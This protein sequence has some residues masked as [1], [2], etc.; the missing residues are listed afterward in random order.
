MKRHLGALLGLVLAWT[1]GPRVMAQPAEL[2]DN[3]KTAASLGPADI[4]AVNAFV[5]AQVQRIVKGDTAAQSDARDSLINQSTNR[6]KPPEAAYLDAYAAAL[7]Q[8]I[9]SQIPADAPIRVRL[10][11]AIATARVA[12]IASN[13][14]LVDAVLRW[15][16][17]QE[18]PVVLW[19]VKGARFVLTPVLDNTPLAQRVKLPQ[20]IVQAVQKNPTGPV[21]QEAYTALSLGVF[22]P[23]A[24]AIKPAWLNDTLPALFDLLGDRV[25]RYVAGVPDEPQAE[26]LATALLV[27]PQVW[28]K[29]SADQRVK[30]VQLMYDL[31]M[32]GSQRLTAVASGSVE[33]ESLTSMVRGTAKAFWVVGTR[34]G[35]QPLVD[36]STQLSRIDV[37]TSGKEVMEL[38]SR[39][40]PLLTAVAEFKDITEAPG[41]QSDG[42]SS[43]PATGTTGQ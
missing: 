26:N 12:E 36:L 23:S 20:A 13:T 27:H 43:A 30:A 35:S 11:A 37:R 25:K 28:P 33:A 22:N 15:L 1:T 34:T 3:L 5:N 9:T 32:L 14:R 8:A 42:V 40:H 39:I 4:Q 21:L 24:T 2:P 31:I 41:I 29:L 17:D 38:A 10:N 19:G 6:G 7:N 18:S 16:G